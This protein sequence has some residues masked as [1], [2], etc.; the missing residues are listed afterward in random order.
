MLQNYKIKHFSFHVYVIP[1]YQIHD[2][3]VISEEKRYI[4]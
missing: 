4:F 1:N 2:E 3:W